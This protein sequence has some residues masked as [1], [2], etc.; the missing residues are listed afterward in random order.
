M[1]SISHLSSIC[2]RCSVPGLL[3]PGRKHCRLCQRRADRMSYY[4]RRFSKLEKVSA[5]RALQYGC[6]VGAVDY[7]LVYAAAIGGPCDL[8]SHV[9]TPDN[10]EFDHVIP[11]AVGGSHTQDNLRLVHRYCNRVQSMRVFILS[12]VFNREVGI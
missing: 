6:L 4:R 9:L 11:L 3:I 2:I 10:V 5:R 7:A 12:R 8:C 1:S